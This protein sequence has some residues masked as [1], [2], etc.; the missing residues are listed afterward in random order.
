MFVEGG[1]HH[2]GTGGS[3][4]VGGGQGSGGGVAARLGPGGDRRFL[5]LLTG[6]PEQ[7]LEYR[8]AG[9]GDDA[10]DACADDGSVHT[11]L[12]REERGDGRGKRA[13]GDLG[14]AQVDPLLLLL[15]VGLGFFVHLLPL[16]APS[17][18]LAWRS[19]QMA[20]L[21]VPNLWN[22]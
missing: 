17:I 12:T 4:G 15:R 16:I 10:D 13:A 18:H 1:Q 9:R 3:R 5:D 22:L 11:E 21:L 6:A 7:V 8:A 2:R 20:E 19:D 14:E